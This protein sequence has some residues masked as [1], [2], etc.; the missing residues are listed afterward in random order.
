MEL[1]S[2]NSKGRSRQ[3]GVEEVGRSGKIK[4]R[5]RKGNTKEIRNHHRVG[6]AQGGG[7]THLVAVRG[8]RQGDEMDLLGVLVMV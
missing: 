3:D 6:R 5:R 2:A 4:G 7:G 8:P 1:Q